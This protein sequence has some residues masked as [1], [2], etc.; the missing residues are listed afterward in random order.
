MPARSQTHLPVKAHQHLSPSFTP[1]CYLIKTWP[2]S[3]LKVYLSLQIGFYVF[4]VFLSFLKKGHF[5]FESAPVSLSNSLWKNENGLSWRTSR[6]TLATVA[7]VITAAVITEVAEHGRRQRLLLVTEIDQS[8]NHRSRNTFKVADIC[9]DK[10]SEK[11]KWVG[12]QTTCR[13]EC[14]LENAGINIMPE[15]IWGKQHEFSVIENY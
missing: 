1:S 3:F 8:E 11:V 13:K 4:C 12:F 10:H 6:G 14:S 2:W 9:V 5:D 7:L 15:F